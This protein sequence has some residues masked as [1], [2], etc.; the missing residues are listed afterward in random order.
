MPSTCPLCHGATIR[1]GGVHPVRGALTPMYECYACGRYYVSS[2]EGLDIL[3]GL[4][5]ADRFVLSA[6][7]RKAWDE[8]APLLLLRDNIRETIEAAP[9]LTLGDRVDRLLLML[10]DR[11]RDYL[12]PVTVNKDHDFPLVWALGPNGMNT[13]HLIGQQRGLLKTGPDQ[14]VLTAEVWERIDAL[15]AAQPDSRQAF[16]AMWFDKSLDDAWENGLKAGVERSRYFRALRVNAVQH[17]DKIDD[18]I[19]AEIR[20]SGLVVADFTGQR[21]GVY[22]EAGFARGLGLRVISTCREN[23][24]DKLH[25]DTRQYNHIFWSSPTDLADQLHDRISATALPKGWIPPT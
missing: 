17:N 23:E 15:R 24:K 25:F 2:P 3:N 10:A 4:A 1:G 19:V 11:A 16:V 7:A 14:L 8:G 5:D 18:R 6:L 9:R 13:L 12:A 21:G 20:R 22:Y